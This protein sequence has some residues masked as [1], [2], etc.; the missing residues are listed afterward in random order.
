MGKIDR[1]NIIHHS[2]QFHKRNED[3]DMHGRRINTLKTICMPDNTTNLNYGSNMQC[4]LNFSYTQLSET[5]FWEY[6]QKADAFYHIPTSNSHEVTFDPTTVKVSKI[7][8][9]SLSQDDAEQ[10]TVSL[11]LTICTKANRVNKRYYLEFNGSQRMISDIDLNPSSGEEDIVNVC[12]TYKLNA[13]A[14]SY[15]TSSGLFSHDSMGFHKFISFSH[16]GDLI[17]SSTVNDMIVI[18]QNITNGGTP[19]APYQI[20]ANAG[21]LHSWICLSVH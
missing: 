6:Y 13:F 10:T 18:G 19:I 3:I 21:A 14:T 20:K 15:W 12:L 11:Q 7:Y 16:Y 2:D 5:L 17:I 9:Q 8:D 4:L 1:S